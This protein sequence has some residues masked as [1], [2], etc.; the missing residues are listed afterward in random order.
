MKGQLERIYMYINA[1]TVSIAKVWEI[2]GLRCGIR[3]K[4]EDGTARTFRNVDT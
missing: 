1:L 2:S 3:L 4:L